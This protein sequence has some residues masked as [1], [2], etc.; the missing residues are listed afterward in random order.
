MSSV[1]RPMAVRNFCSAAMSR[2]NRMPGGWT[3]HRRDLWARSRAHTWGW[4]RCR[5]IGRRG[6]AFRSLIGS[7]SFCGCCRRRRSMHAMIAKARRCAMRWHTP[8][9]RA[10]HAPR[11]IRH[12]I[13]DLEAHIEQGAE[14]RTPASASA[15][16]PPLSAATIP[17]SVRRCA[18]PRRHDPHGGSQGCRRGVGEARVSDLWRFPG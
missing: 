1:V 14:L 16:S 15:S 3:V 12:A 18:E 9:S 2:R 17:H 5:S 10:D 8:G 4:H 6:R 13:A 11:L 7:R